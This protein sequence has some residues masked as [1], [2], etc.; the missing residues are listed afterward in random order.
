[1]FIDYYEAGFVPIPVRPNSK[2]PT[3]GA[4]G[5][6]NWTHDGISRKLVESFDELYPLEKGFGIGILCG[7]ASNI[8]VLDIDTDNYEIMHACPPSPVRRRGK[9]GEARFFQYNPDL[10]N[11]SFTRKDKKGNRE[12]VDLLVESKYI[13][14]PPSVH[15]ETMKP[16]YWLTPDDLLDYGASDLP[17]LTP[18]QWDEVGAAM[19][20]DP[21]STS[22][23]G[24]NIEL[25]GT[26]QSPDGTRAPHGSHDRLKA[27]AH[28]LITECTPLDD[29]VKNLLRYDEQHHKGVGYFDDR[30]RA[31]DFGADRFSNAARLYCNFLKRTNESRI[32]Q[33]LPSQ[34]PSEK[35][36]LEISE[37]L[38]KKPIVDTSFKTYPSPRGQMLKFLQYCELMGKGRQDALGLG[39][40]LTMIAGV[41]ANRFRSEVRGLQVWPNIY[42]LNL[43][44]SSFG[45]DCSQ[46]LLDDLFAD[47]NLVGS[48]NYKSGTSMVQDLPTQQERVDIIDECSWLLK[49][50]HQG[51][52]FQ[53][54]MVE[55]LSLLFSRSSK[56]FNGIASAQ[57]G[58]RHGA[59]YNP[60]VNIIMSTTPAGFKESVNKDMA[61]KG[62]MPRFL[63]FFQKQIGEY[64]GQQNVDKANEVK[65]ELQKFVDGV[66]KI[67]KPLHPDFA[68]KTNYIAKQ[69]AKTTVDLSMGQRYLPSLIPFTDKAHIQWL[70]YEKKNHYKSAKNPDS[71]ESA[72][73][74]RFAEIA[75]KIAL[76]D[77]I[78]LVDDPD[79]FS[80]E[81]F[82]SIY[83]PKIEVDSLD[84]AIELI[85][86]CW[87][88][89]QPLYELT[90]AENKL[91][92]A[93]LRIV[94]LMRDVGGIM[95][96]RELGRKTQWLSTSQRGD[97]LKALE[98]TGQIERVTPKT[99]KPGPKPTVYRLTERGA[100]ATQ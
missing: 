25:K 9:K 75:A 99:D 46:S 84:W 12:G 53:S 80:N 4:F 41:A 18:E 19:G 27:L 93:H 85:E 22:L 73:Y 29:A 63:T 76:L 34:V 79:D 97:I 86:T 52:N 54:E 40:A 28:G 23:G 17:I 96:A 57:H 88:N 11:G 95:P 62:L 35:V 71:F 58:G 37:D 74:G 8:V 20:L 31:A 49:S 55:I 2:E 81:T 51:E 36:V 87:L 100:D 60:C 33:G 61:S 77:R 72:F 32:R 21:V 78:S 13:I 7:R 39:G 1:M 68:P 98:E 91:E 89:S 6:N 70:S 94:S 69:K 59:A 16:Y 47:T 48:A 44:Y 15:P 92:A 83:G 43:G 24:S 66:L 50:M 14:L 42:I 56:R 3:K 64:K 45:K 26:W 65:D 82:G 90:T 5:F 30:R 10:R 67:G 38:L